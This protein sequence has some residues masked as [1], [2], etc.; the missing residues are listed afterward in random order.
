MNQTQ[1]WSGQIQNG[2]AKLRFRWVK[3]RFRWVKLILKW[4]KLRLVSVKP[5]SIWV[6]LYWLGFNLD[7]CQLN[8][9]LL[10]KNGQNKS[11]CGE[12]HYEVKAS[13][14]LKLK[15]TQ[16]VLSQKAKFT[17]IFYF[18]TN[19]IALQLKLDEFYV[20]Q[21]RERESFLLPPS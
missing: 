14:N 9:I 19:C 21:W 6:K 17:A 20:R 12:T 11:N 10:L 1:T 8:F 7:W 5:K 16:K 3:L 13:K 4:I 2:W 18:R 15:F